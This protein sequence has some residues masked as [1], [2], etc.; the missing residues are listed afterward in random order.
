MFILDDLWY[1]NINPT[2]NRFDANQYKL[3]CKKLDEEENDLIAELSTKTIDMFENYNNTLLEV[4]NIEKCAAFAKGYRLGVLM[5]F[6]VF[7]IKD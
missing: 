1:G 5:M 3:L 6:D 4:N 2:E 7:S